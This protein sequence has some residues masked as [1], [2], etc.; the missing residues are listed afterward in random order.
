AVGID[1]ARAERTAAR[2]APVLRAALAEA[3][4]DGDRPWRRWILEHRASEATLGALARADAAELA[5]RG[6]L[7]PDHVIRTK[8]PHLFLGGDLPLDDDEK[9]KAR[10]HHEVERYR[11]DYD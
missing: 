11:R 10:L 9:L 5:R 4:N 2:L 1:L 7:T 3:T 6:P 8:G